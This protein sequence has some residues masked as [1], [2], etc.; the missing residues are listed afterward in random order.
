MLPVTDHIYLF[1]RW[2]W[3]IDA[4]R[5]YLNSTFP[6]STILTL[7]AITFLTMA[8]LMRLYYPRYPP[9]G[10]Q[11]GSGGIGYH[12]LKIM[13]SIPVLG[14]IAI[15]IIEIFTVSQSIFLTV[16]L[17][18]ISMMPGVILPAVAYVCH[19]ARNL[20]NRSEI[21]EVNVMEPTSLPEQTRLHESRFISAQ[22]Q[23]FTADDIHSFT[24]RTDQATIH[25]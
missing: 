12:A 14:V 1:E 8:E 17:V 11:A 16:C 21:E 25:L 3:A 10:L 2:D 6:H 23:C 5:N 18:V 19:R 22:V 9:E 24:S 20:A 15:R 4:Y 13:F 7:C